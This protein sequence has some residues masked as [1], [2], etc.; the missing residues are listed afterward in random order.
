MAAHRHLRHLL[1]GAKIME[2]VMKK[3]FAAVALAAVVASPALAASVHRHQA[4]ANAMASDMSQ[5]YMQSSG[6]YAVGPNGAA[7]GTDPDPNVR[8]SLRILGDTNWA[9]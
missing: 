9:D 4:A 5:N 7:I 1:A 2:T 3:I 6:F 8:Q